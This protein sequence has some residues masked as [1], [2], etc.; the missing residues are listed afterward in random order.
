MA[1]PA[2]AFTG[3]VFETHLGLLNGAVAA[4]LFP[5]LDTYVMP[6]EVSKAFKG[7]E[8]SKSLLRKV[9]S[10]SLARCCA[11][12]SRLMQGQETKTFFTG[13]AFLGSTYCYASCSRTPCCPSKNFSTHCHDHMFH[14]FRVVPSQLRLW[15]SL[16]WLCSPMLP[17][18][19]TICSYFR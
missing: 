5:V 12:P 19:S 14:V 9:E 18:S 2:S 7:K 4:L 13:G 10:L 15:V 6:G 17:S 3:V 1:A 8:R 16:V 11:R